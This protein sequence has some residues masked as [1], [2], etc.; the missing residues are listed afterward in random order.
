MKS[1][2]QGKALEALMSGMSSGFGGAGGAGGAP[3]AMGATGGTMPSF[4]PDDVYSGMMGKG[5]GSFADYLQNS[6]IDLNTMFA[7]GDIQSMLDQSNISGIE[8]GDPSAKAAMM[9]RPQE[10]AHASMVN[11]LINSGGGDRSGAA[12]AV[13]AGMG[14]ADLGAARGQAVGQA[15]AE[16]QGLAALR[17]QANLDARLK[18]TGLLKQVL[19]ERAGVEAGM[20]QG[21]N[22]TSLAAL[23]AAA[24]Y[25]GQQQKL[26]AGLMPQYN[27]GFSMGQGGQWMPSL[28]IS[29]YGGWG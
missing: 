21:W 6:G 26:M 24:E 15:S 29:G 8:V 11:N 9:M 16:T 22:A 25:K 3:W 18:L 14:G 4:T 17:G 10:Q 1:Y 23:S 20:L 12:A 13:M 5:Q 19:G 28:D 2:D 27:M 7:T